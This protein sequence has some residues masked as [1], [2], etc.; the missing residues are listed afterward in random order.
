MTQ[1]WRQPTTDSTVLLEHNNSNQITGNKNG[2]RSGMFQ[3]INNR[4]EPLNKRL[5]AWIDFTNQLFHYFYAHWYSSTQPILDTRHICATVHL[6]THKKALIGWHGWSEIIWQMAS[7]ALW[8]YIQFHI[9]AVSSKKTSNVCHL[10]RFLTL[11]NSNNDS[12][13]HI[14]LTRQLVL[15]LIPDKYRYFKS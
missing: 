1:I 4:N 9:D 11:N 6:V 7:S 10:L 2:Y 5:S 3:T 14:P 13:V 8:N 12:S 15:N